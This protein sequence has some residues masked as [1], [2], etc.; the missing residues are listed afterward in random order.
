MLIAIAEELKTYPIP[1]NAKP[2]TLSPDAALAGIATPFQLM[3][4]QGLLSS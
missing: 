3:T 2:H 4:D 1:P